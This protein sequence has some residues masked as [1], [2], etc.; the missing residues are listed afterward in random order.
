MGGTAGVESRQGEGS[1]F[2]LEIRVRAATL[3]R[4]LVASADVGGVPQAE[5]MYSAP[6]ESVRAMDYLLELRGLLRAGL[7]DQALPRFGSFVA[8]GGNV[9][10]IGHAVNAGMCQ[11]R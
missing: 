1:I 8:G 5:P 3:D 10:N 4:L 2:W 6:G 7:T 11:W 9:P